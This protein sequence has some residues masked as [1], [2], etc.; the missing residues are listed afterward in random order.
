MPVLREYLAEEPM[1]F[2]PGNGRS[3]AVVM[4]LGGIAG[5]AIVQRHH[6]EKR[7]SQAE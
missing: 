2:D 3:V 4:A 1:T 5:A 6:D 7:K